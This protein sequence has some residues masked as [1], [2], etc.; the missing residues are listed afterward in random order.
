M[1]IVCIGDSLTYGYS[2][3]KKYRWTNL[4][5]TRLNIDIINKGVN[6][7]TTA[8]ML[9]RSY[10]DVIKNNPTHTIIMGGTND[11]MMGYS[12]KM[13]ADNIIELIKEAKTHKIIPIIVI[14]MSTSVDLAARL[15]SS[16]TDFVDVNNKIASYRKLMIEYCTKNNIQY[17]DLY[18]EFS[19][20]LKDNNSNLYY[21]DGIH[22]TTKG[23]E[24]IANIL[25]I[26]K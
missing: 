23:H 4:I 26:K 5:N 15:W 25:Y 2:V 12:E 16:Y 7:N 3:P 24:V 8:D 20:A 10:E 19:N 9:F 11:F 6:G 22:P 17:F 14:Q 18:K 13:V 1:K 21:I